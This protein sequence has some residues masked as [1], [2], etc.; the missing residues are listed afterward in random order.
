[1]QK[2]GGVKKLVLSF[3]T[4]PFCR[5]IKLKSKKNKA[6]TPK[7]GAVK[8]IEFFTAPVFYSTPLIFLFNLPSL[9]QSLLLLGR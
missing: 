9:F 3:L 2:N 4:P 1:M 6:K 7:I 8:N 5:K